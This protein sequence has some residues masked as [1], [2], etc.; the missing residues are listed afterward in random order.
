T[1]FSRDWSSDVC[2]SD[3]GRIGEHQVGLGKVLAV[4]REGITALDAAFNA[5][6]HEVHQAQTVRV[7]HQL[8]S[9]ECLVAL[10]VR[11][12]FGQLEQRSE[13]RRVGTEWRCGWA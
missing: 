3:L 11:L 6:Q 5:V 1:R 13:E 2:S 9:D 7:R 10:E 12:R 8:Q 4:G